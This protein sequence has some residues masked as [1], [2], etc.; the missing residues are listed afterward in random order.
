MSRM[1]YYSTL[2][3]FLCIAMHL[4]R[5]EINGFKSFAGKT[6]LE[7][8]SGITAI[9]GPNGS[10]KS[11]VVDAVRWLLGERDA[12]NL[13]GAKVDDL[14]FAG[15]AKRPRLGMA[16]ASLHFENKNNFFPVD[17][18]EVSVVRQI[19]LAH[20]WEINAL[21]NGNAGAT[22]RLSGLKLV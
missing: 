18:S 2:C 15:T 20:G 11:N 13:R 14:I 12:K 6:V 1:L 16:T 5:M 9:V 21:T 3:I 7:F 4:K 8:P 10:G 22:F 17:F 19:A